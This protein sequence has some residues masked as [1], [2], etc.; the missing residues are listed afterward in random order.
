MH[1]L[2]NVPMLPS[3]A[4]IRKMRRQMLSLAQSFVLIYHRDP[5]NIV[6]IAF[7]RDLLR[8]ADN[9]RIGD[10][11][12]HPWFITKDMEVVQ[13]LHQFRVNKETVAVVLSEQGKPIGV[14]T[15]DDVLKEIFG[16]GAAAIESE[17]S[18]LPPIIEKTFPGCMQ[19]REFNQ[20]YEVK[21]E[22]IHEN[23]TLAD[24]LI[25][26]FGHHP[27]IGEV[28]KIPPFEMEVKEATLLEI[29]QVTIKTKLS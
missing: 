2:K 24:M 1:S 16:H 13:I 25:R 12:R 3:N 17:P 21:L 5:L 7:A 26:V 14:I 9:R 23:E 28:V 22:A 27:E 20:L 8:E 10:H 15:L 19:V 6:G 18:Q 29:K 4:P 11:S